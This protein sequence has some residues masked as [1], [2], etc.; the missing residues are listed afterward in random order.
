ML[1]EG[2]NST[3]QCFYLSI[4]NSSSFALS[5]FRPR[6]HFQCAHICH[7]AACQT[8]AYC[9]GL[10]TNIGYSLSHVLNIATGKNWPPKIIKYTNF[11][12]SARLNDA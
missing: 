12:S 5:D 10:I 11:P 3:S 7:P 2:T 6:S 4:R 8:I 9:S 1:E